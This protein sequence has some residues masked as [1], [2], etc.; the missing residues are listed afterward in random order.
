MKLNFRIDWGYQYLYTRRTYH[1]VYNWD[2][3]ISVT[4]GEILNI[5]KLDYPIIWFGPVLNAV[6]TKLEKPEWKDS[7]KRKLSGIRLE[8]EVSEE[9]VFTLN[10]STKS[11]TFSAKDVL[12]KGRLEFS[13]GPKYLGC[14]IMVT[15]NDYLWFRNPLNDGETA[16]EPEDFGMPVYMWART[17]L[18]WVNPGESAKWEYEVKCSGDMTETLVHTVIM[19]VPEY[20]EDD[21][22][23]VKDTFPLELLVDGES[24]LNFKRYYRFH[25]D[26]VQLLEDDF[27]KISVPEGKHTFELKN[28]HKSLCIGINR[29]IMRDFSYKHGDLYIPD[30]CLLGE[31]LVGKVFSKEDGTITINSADGGV[32]EVEAKR[33][34]TEFEFIAKQEGNI[35]LYTDTDKKTIEVFDI[36]EEK[37]PVKVG[38]DMTVVPHNDHGFF[39]FLLEYSSYTRFVNYVLFRNFYTE[40]PSQELCQRWGRFFKK[41]NMYAGICF[42]YEDGRVINALGDRMNDAG[43]HEY[44]GRVYG[45]DPVKPYLSDDMKT[46]SERYIDFLKIKIDEVHNLHHTASFGDASGGIRYSYLAGLDFCR[47]ETMVG[48]TMTLLTQARPAAESLGNGRWGVHIATQHGYQPY[49]ETQ[50]GTYFLSLMQPWMMGAELMY[51]EDCLFS[52]WKEERQAWDDLLAR[53]KR[54][55]T[56]DFFKFVKTHPRQGKSKRNIAFVEGRYAAPF[57]GFVCGPEQDP[58]YSVW[59]MFGCYNKEWGHSQPERCRQ[60]LNVLMPGAS[61]APLRQDFTKRRFYFAGTPY[62][63]FDCIPTE[64]GVDYFENYKLLLHLGWNTMIAEDYDKLKMYVENGGVLLTSLLQFSTHTRRD[65][66]SDFEDI[67]LYN[68]GDL[69][70]FAGIKVIG[71][72]DKEYSSSWNSVDRENMPNPEIISLPNDFEGE[73]GK[74]YIA[75]IELTGAEIVA[76]DSDSGLPLLVRNKVGKGYIYTFTFWAYPGHE[77]LQSIS[78][79]WVEKLSQDTLGD[80]YIKDE[81]G[82]IFWTRW[83]NGEENIYMLLNT[84]WSKKGN[85]KIVTLVSNGKETEFSVKE[86]CALIIKVKNGK[87][88]KEEYAF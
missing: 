3:N 35:E 16:F 7:T 46:A 20:Q 27:K 65:F 78:S 57:S 43:L 10:T 69:T 38:M 30:W 48:N 28:N 12:E 70:D 85:V 21:K 87:T 15:L 6:E 84:D 88:E 58:H 37:Y 18:A 72:S 8:T 62:G 45:A 32:I 63:D 24:V 14:R 75:D 61:T 11:V 34:W 19:A 74:A 40:E 2:G 77:Q 67:S 73:D 82:E 68:G 52:V 33:G 31:K 23:P 50:L 25:D 9:S 47:A 17:K 80:E 64:A 56:R 5:Y 36:P 60:L 59:G 4:D 54:D 44:P 86:R 26:W 55:M 49:H 39:D 29:I 71:R 13:V 41:H 22:K 81:S 51:E 79:A 83:E 76:W 66:L 1:P 53:G 42:E